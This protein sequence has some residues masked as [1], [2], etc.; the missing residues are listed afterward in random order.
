MSTSAASAKTWLNAAQRSS[1]EIEQT[2]DKLYQRL[3]KHHDQPE[4]DLSGSEAAIEVLQ[5]ELDQRVL[6]A[7]AAQPSLDTSNLGSQE[8]AVSTPPKDDEEKRQRFQSLK[9]QLSNM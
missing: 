8:V 9:D 5:T 2:I 3:E 1:E 6:A 4:I 7:Q